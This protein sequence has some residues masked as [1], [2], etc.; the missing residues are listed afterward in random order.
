MVCALLTTRQKAGPGTAIHKFIKKKPFPLSYRAVLEKEE[1][2]DFIVKTLRKNGII[3]YNNIAKYLVSNLDKLEDGEWENA[4]KEINRLSGSKPTTKDL[5]R[6]AAAY[7]R[8]TFKGFGPK[9]SRNLLQMLGLTR[10]EIPI[11]SRMINWLEE[12][13]YPRPLSSKL[14]GDRKYY[15]LVL[16]DIQ[17]LC[18]KAGVKPCILDAA[19]FKVQ[20]G[21]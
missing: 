14:L 1:L 10:Y 9:Q 17:V 5:E 4:L 7:I 3:Y 15:E 6:A 2:G 8:I 13:G 21:R 16:A 19:V 12:F 20:G 11:D 18:R